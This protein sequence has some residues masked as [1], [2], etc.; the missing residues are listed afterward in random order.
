M[1]KWLLVVTLLLVAGCTNPMTVDLHNGTFC[2]SQRVGD[3]AEEHN[4][5][6]EQA[7]DELRE[8]ADA[9]WAEEE[10]KQAKLAK[11]KPTVVPQVTRKP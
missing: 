4:L 5:T 8:K 2:S 9:L 3:Y 7:L 1:N 10:A 11:P 6:Y